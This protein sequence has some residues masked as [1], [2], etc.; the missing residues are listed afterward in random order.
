MSFVGSS[1][2]PSISDFLN[3]NLSDFGISFGIGSF[4]DIVFTVSASHIKTFD[5]FSRRSAAKFAD[6]EIAGR[7]PI[8][9]FTGEELDEITFNIQLNRTY[10]KP[11]RDLM[12]LNKIKSSG[13]A[14]RLIIGSRNLGKFTLREFEENLTHVGKNG[15]ILFAEVELTLT[16]YI[17][18][19]SNNASTAQ[20]ED[21]VRR[22]E[23]GKGGPQ[24]LPGSPPSSSERPMTPAQNETGEDDTDE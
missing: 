8:S 1:S 7:K 17:D 15:A 2:S 10:A 4:G 5:E 19:Y 9:E 3:F 11:E 20:R 22:G 21:E 12:L 23:T 14:N 24:R 18:S 16:E 6:H 13:I